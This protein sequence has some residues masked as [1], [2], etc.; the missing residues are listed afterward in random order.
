MAKLK[1]TTIT[2]GLNVTG[3]VILEQQPTV[4][5]NPATK[6]YVDDAIFN[7]PMITIEN[8]GLVDGQ[9]LTS[10]VADNHEITATKATFFNVLS[11]TGSGNAITNITS[12]GKTLTATKGSVGTVTNVGGTGTVSGLT[13]SGTVSTTGNLTLGGTLSVLP[14]NFTSQTAKTFLAAPNASNGTPTFRTILASDI[15]TLNQNTTGSA[16]S[17]ATART[18][19][20]G[21]GVTSTP[22]AFNGSS[23][24]TIPVTR[25]SEA[26]LT[27]GGKNLFESYGPIDAAMVNELGANR[28]AFYPENKIL[29]EYSLD[30]G[31][32]WLDYVA[33]PEEKINLFNGIGTTLRIGKNTL[34]GI[35][36]SNYQ[37]RVTLT[38][39]QGS[40]YTVLNK[41]VMLISTNGSRGVW[42]TIEGRLQSNVEASVDTWE[43][44][45]NQTAIGGWSGYNVININPFTTY[46][47][48][49]SKSSQYGQVRFLFG[50]T[51]ANQA[52]SGLQVLKILG[53]GGVGWSTPS[54][55]AKQGNIYTY[56][57]LQ[58][59]TFP[60]TVTGTRLISNVATGTAPFTV[61]STTQVN[62]LNADLL[63]GQH[64]SYY[65]PASTAITTTN[66]GS[67][68]VDK[69]NKLTTARTLTIGGTDKSFDGSANV[70]WSL[71]ELGVITSWGAS[72]TN[73]TFP[74]S[75]LVKDTIDALVMGTVTTIDGGTI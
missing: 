2:G 34:T 75:K 74:S 50:C 68:T 19:G 28:L 13:L 33:T 37:L 14:S 47:N 58:D 21:T 54:N 20:L 29:V 63:D 31:S 16:G 39:T 24:I 22:T 43:I 11:S 25:V 55:L 53:F 8:G 30:R 46:G 66:I 70:T 69:A 51:T 6:K 61:A 59:T 12:S 65:Q 42:T 67:Q 10:I 7:L 18:I 4:A 40:L 9:A 38:E 56:N 41:F 26:Y 15:P 71:A 60:G 36:Y 32:T 1:D 17:L 44:F 45:S 23:N 27:W 35:D 52:Y 72:P 73:S 5:K 62:N 49:S 64:G 48:S 3:D 57:Y